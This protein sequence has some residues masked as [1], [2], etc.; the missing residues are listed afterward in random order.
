MR[1]EPISQFFTKYHLDGV[2][3]LHHFTAPDAHGPHD[4]PWDF[5]STIVKGW[6]IEEIY[7]AD[8]SVTRELHRPGETFQVTAEHIHRIVKVP[9]EGCWTLVV[10]EPARREPLWWAFDAGESLGLP[11]IEKELLGAMSTKPYPPSLIAQGMEIPYGDVVTVQRRLEARGFAA[12]GALTP[13]G[14]RWRR[15]YRQ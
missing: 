14:E 9:E 3:V 6:Y 15:A 10:A 13:A 11:W 5:Q 8:G 4:H 1:V 7:A 2:N 12:G